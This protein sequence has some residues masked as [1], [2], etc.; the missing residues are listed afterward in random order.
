MREIEFLIIH[1]SDSPDDMDIGAKEIRDWHVNGNG[2]SDI[3]YNYVIRRNG[4]IE[5]GRNLEIVPAHCKGYNRKSIGICLVGR[6]IFS[7]EQ[8][9]SLSILCMGLLH[10]FPKVSIKGHRDF[11][12]EKT[13]PNFDVDEFFEDKKE[14]IDCLH[15]QNY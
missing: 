12:P 6:K 5:I 10:R 14:F 1:C 8:F 3:G 13:C 15:Y 2:W 4:S 9:S 11:N 7:K